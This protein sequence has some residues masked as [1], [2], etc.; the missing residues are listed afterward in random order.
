MKQKE[1]ETMRHRYSKGRQ[2]AFER[3]RGILEKAN[4]TV[5][6][7]QT[8]DKTGKIIKSNKSST[9]GVKEE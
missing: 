8:K 5:N 4:Y 9:K 6:Q 7:T 1:I 3:V 2:K